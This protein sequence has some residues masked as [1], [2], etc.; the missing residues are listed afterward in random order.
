MSSLVAV[1][2]PKVFRSEG[3]F[4]RNFLS[5]LA[6]K[7]E[8]R[9]YLEIGV[10]DGHSLK[11][12]SV[13]E[14]IAVDPGLVLS[15]DPTEGKEVTH[16]YRMTSDRFFET[17]HTDGLDL[18]FLDGMHL[19]EYLLRDFYNT[20]ACCKANGLITMHDCLP[21]D[22]HMISRTETLI[23]GWT[24]DVWKII[25]ILEKYRPD[26]GIV[27]VDCLPTGLVCITNLDP[28]STVLKEHYLEI[29]NEYRTMPNDA[30]A[31]EAFYAGRKIMSAE[32]IMSGFDHSLYF[33]T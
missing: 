2:S 27:C 16:F 9:K 8:V 24:G 29:V 26:L 19:F 13:E 17:Q 1:Q 31:L 11:G 23:G 25:P 4:Y 7:R 21:V 15:C 5:A 33:R 28:L 30:E 20:E 32:V 22:G 14:A 18:A 12:V 3:I 6:K 10:Q